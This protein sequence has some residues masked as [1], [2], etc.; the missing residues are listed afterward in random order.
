MIEWCVK[1]SLK[2]EWKGKEKETDAT[3]GIRFDHYQKFHSEMTLA[4]F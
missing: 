1:E 2:I 3:H 4:I